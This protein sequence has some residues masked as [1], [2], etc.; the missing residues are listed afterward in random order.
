MRLRTSSSA[1]TGRPAPDPAST[2]LLR[3]PRQNSA[4]DADDWLLIDRDTYMYMAQDF[5]HTKTM[6]HKLRRLLQDVSALTSG[7]GEGNCGEW[8]T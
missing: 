4:Q 3:P 6:L 7:G 2:K 8:D 5:T 1:D